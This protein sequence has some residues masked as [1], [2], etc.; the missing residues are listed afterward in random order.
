VANARFVGTEE[1]KRCQPI[2]R[3]KRKKERFPEEKGV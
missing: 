3:L 2:I 1:L